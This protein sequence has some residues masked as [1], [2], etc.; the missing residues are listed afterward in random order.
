MNSLLWISIYSF[1]TKLLAANRLITQER[2]KFDIE[3]KSSTFPLEIMTQLSAAFNTKSDLE[4]FLRGKSSMYIKNYRDTRFDLWGTPLFNV[5]KAQKKNF[6]WIRWCYFNFLSSVSY[7]A[8][9][10]NLQLHVE[11]HRIVNELIISYESH[12]EL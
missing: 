4:F 10:K 1:R 6:I 5:L 9:E 7:T 3:Q 11:F 8:P 12:N 2:T